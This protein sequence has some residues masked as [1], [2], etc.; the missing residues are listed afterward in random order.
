MQRLM[1]VSDPMAKKPNGVEL[2]CVVC[3]LPAKDR[4]IRED[5]GQHADVGF[6]AEV[7]RDTGRVPREIDEV[8]LRSLAW[9][10][11][12]GAAGGK[13]GIRPD[14]LHELLDTGSGPVGYLL[15]GDGA[16]NL[17]AV[18]APRESRRDS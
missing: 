16:D 6:R 14:L 2:R 11:R 3:V 17:M 4:E 9:M 10:V 1:N 13:I 18:V 8:L 15:H 5:G 12:E 7:V